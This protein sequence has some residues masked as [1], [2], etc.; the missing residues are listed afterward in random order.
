MQMAT[1][2]AIWFTPNI[3]KWIV[4]MIGKKSS[5]MQHLQDFLTAV[6]SFFHPSNTGKFQEDLVKFLLALIE[7]FV[8]RLHL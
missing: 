5:C 6:K 4:A 2:K 7:Q 1:Q 3:A 8:D